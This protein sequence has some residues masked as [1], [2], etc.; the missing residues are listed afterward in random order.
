MLNSAFER[1]HAL[2]LHVQISCSDRVDVAQLHEPLFPL[3]LKSVKLIGASPIVALV[4][5]HASS[6]TRDICTST[7][8]DSQIIPSLLTHL[9]SNSLLSTLVRKGLSSGR[10]AELRF[11]D[12]VTGAARSFVFQLHAMPHSHHL[13]PD[14][15]RRIT[16]LTIA[17]RLFPLAEAMFPVLP[18]LRMLA[19]CDGIPYPCDLASQ[20]PQLRLHCEALLKFALSVPHSPGMLIEVDYI[21]HF[22]GHALAQTARRCVC[23]ATNLAFQDISIEF[24]RCCGRLSRRTKGSSLEASSLE[25]FRRARDTHCCDRTTPASN[26]VEG[27]EKHE[28]ASVPP[29]ACCGRPR[30][31]RVKL[32]RDCSLVVRSVRLS[33]PIGMGRTPGRRERRPT[34][35]HETQ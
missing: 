35:Q 7:I 4:S 15:H 6:S 26:C 9:S 18:S 33:P 29:S 32:R 8:E 20:E 14:I 2:V 17:A 13:G 23:G 5:R 24:S 30:I 12:T 11:E 31:F 22:M 10:T 27:H 19:V 25:A 16:E 3:A 21:L 34:L 1:L 28:F